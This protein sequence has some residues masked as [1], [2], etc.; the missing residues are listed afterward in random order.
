M[1]VARSAINSQ[2][3]MRPPTMSFKLGLEMVRARGAP[4]F[5]DR[6]H[7]PSLL[8]P[9]DNVGFVVAFNH[10]LIDH[11]FL[12]VAQRR[13]VVHGVEQHILQN[14]AKSPRARL[15]LHRLARH[16]TEGIFA[17]VELHALHVEK[18]AV[19]LGER[20]LR[21]HQDRNQRVFVQ[22]LQRRDHRQAAHEFGNQ[23]VLDQILGLRVVEHVVAVRP[24]VLFAHLGDE[25]DAALVRAVHDDLL[26]SGERTAADEQD[27]G[28]VDLQKFLLRMFAAA[29]RR[30]GGDRAF[31]QFQERLLH[32]FARD[33]AGDRRVIGLAGDLVDFIDVDDAGLRL[34]DI[35]IAFLQQL[36]DDVFDVFADVAGL[37]QGRRIG[38]GKGHVEQ[39]RQ[40]FGQQRLTGP[41]RSDQQD[42][43]L[44]ELHFVAGAHAL[45]AARLQ[46]LVV[47][48]DRHREDPLGAF[49]PDDVFI[50][51]FLDF[52][53]LGELV[54]GT[55]GALFQFFPNYVVAQLHAFVADENA[56]AGDEFPNLVLA[57]STERAVQQLAVIMFATRIF[58]HAVLKLTAR[59]EKPRGKRLQ[60]RLYS[61][62]PTSRKDKVSRAVMGVR[63]GCRYAQP[64]LGLGLC[65]NFAAL[66]EHGIHQTVRPGSFRGHK[67]VPVAVL[68]DALDGLA[69]VLGQYAIQALF[70]LHDVAGVDVDVGGLALKPS[71]GLVNHDF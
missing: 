54:A 17:E 13:Q 29:L 65:R 70:G 18:L 36:L 58:A 34:F 66:L 1:V 11:D 8:G 57:L 68:L 6:S 49:L 30:H 21:L 51:D 23:A 4:L 71:R 22:F 41:G 52:L 59:P 3:Y 46:A 48:V 32:A 37:G 31:N 61:T 60:Y 25:A 33:I 42:I 9:M 38:D 62:R 45:G 64:G 50:E 5:L 14:G 12:H 67:V 24:R 53:G 55:L 47:I 27:V 19:L 28:R 44:G 69:R 2:R 40:R 15:A 10:L 20:I 63:L 43:A 35:V 39:S 7:Q 26:E 16:R 56:G